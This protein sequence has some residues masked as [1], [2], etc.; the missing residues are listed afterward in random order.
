LGRGAGLARKELAVVM[1]SNELATSTLRGLAGIDGLMPFVLPFVGVSKNNSS[2]ILEAGRDPC[3]LRGLEDG[4][5][6]GLG[7][8]VLLRA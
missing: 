4:A 7:V 5:L 3:W 8:D 2:F 6:G 1:A